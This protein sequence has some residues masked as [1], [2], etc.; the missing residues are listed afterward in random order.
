MLLLLSV[1][2]LAQ[3]ATCH[4]EEIPVGGGAANA[5]ICLRNSQSVLAQWQEEH[6]EYHVEKWRCASRGA[7]PKKL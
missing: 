4:D 3:P 5:F 6:P 7:A 1:C 2:L